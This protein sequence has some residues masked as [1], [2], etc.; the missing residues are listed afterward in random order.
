MVSEV[1]RFVGLWWDQASH[2]VEITPI[3]LDRLCDL[4]RADLIG[5]DR[6]EPH[7]QRKVFNNRIPQRIHR[8]NGDPR[9][10]KYRWTSGQYSERRHR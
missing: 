7:S 3:S 2:M 6:L 10:G 8:Y 5:G 4:D 9:P 1:L